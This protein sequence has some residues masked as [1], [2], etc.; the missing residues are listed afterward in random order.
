MSV[1][2][3]ATQPEEPDAYDWPALV[4]Q[5][6][7]LLRLRTTLIGMKLFQSDA[8]AGLGVSYGRSKSE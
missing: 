2:I 6:N 7:R 4:D 5:L 8:R 1:R 3:D